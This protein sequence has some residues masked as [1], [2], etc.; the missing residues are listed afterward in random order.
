MAEYLAEM[1]RMEKLFNGFEV[2]YVPQLDNR[3][4]D[5]LV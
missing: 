5:H 3:G 4:A 1:H 2:Q